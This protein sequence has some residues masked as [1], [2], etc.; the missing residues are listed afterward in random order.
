MRKE[1]LMLRGLVLSALAVFSSATM[2]A[3]RIDLEKQGKAQANSASAFT[4]VSQGDL[5]ALR[6]TQFASGKV[7]TRYQQYYQ[8]CRSGAKA[9]WRKSR[10]PR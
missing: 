10:P 6:S 7:V 8:G 5:K 3:E 4:G 2:A 1:Q 9:W